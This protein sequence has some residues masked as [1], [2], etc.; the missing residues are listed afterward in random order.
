MR[1][2]ASRA[3]TRA[4]DQEGE[5]PSGAASAD[6]WEPEIAILRVQLASATDKNRRLLQEMGEITE[7]MTVWMERRHPGVWGRLRQQ[8]PFAQSVAA[9][10]GFL[11]EHEPVLLKAPALPRR[12]SV[13]GDDDPP[14]PAPPPAAQTPAPDP[15]SPVVLGADAPDEEQG[16]EARQGETQGAERTGEDKEDKTS[17]DGAQVLMSYSEWELVVIKTIGEGQCFDGHLA[18][19]VPDELRQTNAPDSQRRQLDGAISRLVGR[20]LIEATALDLGIPNEAVSWVEGQRALRLTSA[21]CQAYQAE[22]G[23]PPALARSRLRPNDPALA[24]VPPVWAAAM[25]AYRSLE[26]YALVRGVKRAILAATAPQEARAAAWQARVFDLMDAEDQTLFEKDPDYARLLASQSRP[27][28]TRWHDSEG[29]EAVPDLVVLM[30][31]RLGGAGM[32]MLVEVERVKYSRQGMIDKLRASIRCYPPSQFC[33][34][35][36]SAQIAG[37]I[38][39]LFKEDALD[40]ETRMRGL[41]NGCKALFTDLRRVALGSWLSVE[42]THRAT[43]AVRAGNTDF[44]AVRGINP[45][46]LAHYWMSEAKRKPFGDQSVK[47]DGDGAADH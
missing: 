37:K 30:Q 31:P 8:L 28:Q 9:M 32:A 45:R 42:Q 2:T 17:L 38:F 3:P 6:S 23:H 14:L 26:S 36:P 11:D 12:V 34:V 4:A 47:G 16:L 19:H 41:P 21:G 46:Y 20:G 29:Q 33:Y 1:H 13:N 7:I 22:L 35:F 43:L 27:F 10:L 24:D 40:P 25:A 18:E 39:A 5:A 15:A 44:P